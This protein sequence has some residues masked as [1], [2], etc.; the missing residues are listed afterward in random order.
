MLYI[1]KDRLSNQS[2]CYIIVHDNELAHNTKV[3]S[4]TTPTIAPSKNIQL[5]HL[6]ERRSKWNFEIAG[7]SVEYGWALAKTH[8]GRS[9]KKENNR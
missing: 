2:Y 3:K 8:Y 1:K 6:L 5:H 9:Q 7:E 4:P